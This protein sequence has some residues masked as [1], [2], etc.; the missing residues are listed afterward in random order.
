M[1]EQSLLCEEKHKNIDARLD[2]HDVHFEKL[3]DRMSKQEEGSVR[4]EVIV[5]H[6]CK[7]IDTLITVLV[8][9]FVTMF[10]GALAF[11][12]WYIQ[13]LPR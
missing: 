6:L 12:I 7:K 1:S 3:D 9:G 10:G 8:G 5:S 2:G 4:T 13:S 11:I